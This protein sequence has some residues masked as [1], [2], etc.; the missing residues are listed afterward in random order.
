[1]RKRKINPSLRSLG[2]SRNRETCRTVELFPGSRVL[3]SRVNFLLMRLR[4]DCVYKF[5]P[6]A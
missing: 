2:Q 1:M 4:F 3:Y 6:A 5:V